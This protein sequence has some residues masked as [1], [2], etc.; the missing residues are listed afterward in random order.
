MARLGRKSRRD[1]LPHFPVTSTRQSSEKCGHC[2]FCVMAGE[3]PAPEYRRVDTQRP[4]NKIVS[5]CRPERRHDSFRA[6]FGI[7]VSG[8]AIAI[9]YV[10]SLRAGR[11]RFRAGRG[12][13]AD[14]D[15]RR[16]L[17]RFC[18]RRR[19][20]RA[21]PFASARGRGDHRAGQEGHPR[22]QPLSHPRR[23]AAGRAALRHDLR[24]QGVFRQFRRRGDGRRHQDGAEVPVRQRPSR[25]LPHHQLR[26]LVPRPHPGDAGRR[27][28]QEASR[29][30]RAGHGRLR[31]GSARRPQGAQA[32]HHAR[33]RRHR[34]RAGAGRGRRALGAAAVLPRAAPALRRARPAARVRRG[35]DRHRPARRN[36]RLPEDRRDARRHGAGQGARRRLSDRRRAGHRGSG[37]GH[38][39]GHPRLDLRRQSAGVR[40]R[41]RGARRGGRSRASSITS[42]T[43]RCCSSSGSPRSRTG[44]PR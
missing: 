30:L 27:Q 8:R 31:P 18:L 41:Q 14:R 36:V 38:D 32:R 7:G 13:L 19:G 43:S 12:R 10:A 28:E 24:R 22:L 4:G 23:R 21:R 17:S 39:A 16:P 15:Q 29:R 44:I 26:G 35:A 40:G 1:S 3:R 37:Q 33:D 34:H 20:Q 11:P 5:T 6:I 9:A 2:R 42:A 25:A